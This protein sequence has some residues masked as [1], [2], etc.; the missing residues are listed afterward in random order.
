MPT[1]C[2]A[3]D[4]ELRAIDGVLAVGTYQRPTMLHVQVVA[5]DLAPGARSQIRELVRT[6]VAEPFVVETLVARP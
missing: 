4:V 6:Y 1:D 3:L 5:Q 2:D